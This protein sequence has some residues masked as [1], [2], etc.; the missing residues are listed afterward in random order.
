[1]EARSSAGRLISSARLS[2]I[3]HAAASTKG[4]QVA[5]HKKVLRARFSAAKIS[6]ALE[7]A[8]TYAAQLAAKHGPSEEFHGKKRA[9]SVRR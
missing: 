1:M 8:T 2:F 6:E 5:T 7:S 3:P 4:E 9:N